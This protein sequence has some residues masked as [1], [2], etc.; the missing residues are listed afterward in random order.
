[1]DNSCLPLS[2]LLHGDGAA[3]R[4]ELYIKYMMNAGGMKDNVF[5]MSST[6]A[7][8]INVIDCATVAAGAATVGAAA[9]I[10]VCVCVREREHCY[11]CQPNKCQCK[12][13]IKDFHF[14]EAAL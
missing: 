11:S 8:M 12:K 6:K 10:G 14:P 13:R 1:M 4:C 5:Q 3:R 7:N 2:L 9:G